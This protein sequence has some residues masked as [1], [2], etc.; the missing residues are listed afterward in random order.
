MNWREERGKMVRSQF[1]HKYECVCMHEIKKQQPPKMYLHQNGCLYVC[2][3]SWYI[4]LCV[5]CIQSIC[6]S[7]CTA[8]RA[9]MMLGLI[10]NNLFVVHLYEQKGCLLQNNRKKLTR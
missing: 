8:L 2:C 9:L 10:R 3:I 1:S 7:N 5:H 6:V 4:Y